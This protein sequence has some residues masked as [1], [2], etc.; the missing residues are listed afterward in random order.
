MANIYFRTDGNSNI[1]M[2]HIMRCL[3]IARACA[4]KGSNVKFIVSDRQSLTLIQKSFTVPHEFEVY[5][6]NSDYTTPTEELTALYA[7]FIQDK[8]AENNSKPWIFVDS[9]YA[10]PS[11]LLS[12]R[13]H[14]RVAYL[15]DLRS[16][17]CPVDL[18]IN[19]DT[20][21]D[22]DHYANAD[23]KLLGV[24]YTPLR[25]QFSTSSYTVRPTVE[26]VLLSTGGTD[27]FAVA[28]RLLHAIYHESS[29]TAPIQDA[30]LLQSL[31]YHILTSSANTRY[32]SL[33]SYARMHPNVHIHEGIPDVASLMASC[34]LAVS[35]GGTTL[36]ELCAVGV[37][38]ISYLMADNQR[39]AVETYAGLG[40]IPYAGDV[41]PANNTVIS[42]ILSFMTYMSQN[43]SLRAK[44]SQSMRAF[45][46]GAGSDQIACALTS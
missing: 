40:L 10:T 42:S 15:D 29:G 19:Y 16:F 22:C 8:T 25:E 43:L 24:Q 41:R 4:K 34:D 11:Y 44:S 33:T 28:E 38:T 6:L 45:L 23:H 2:G 13:E 5:C 17:D 12:L 30:Q 18:V 14:F 21:K 36:C 37:P 39:T 35:A 1:A 7:L 9:Y 26:H 46:N 3:A 31:H 27:P 20:D 32:D